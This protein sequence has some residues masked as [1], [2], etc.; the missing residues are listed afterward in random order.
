MPELTG[1]PSIV[2]RVCTAPPRTTKLVFGVAENVREANTPGTVASV[3]VRLL[4]WRNEISIGGSDEIADSEML[5]GV[6]RLVVVLVRPMTRR[7]ERLLSCIVTLTVAGVPAT[8]A[9]SFCVVWK[10]PWFTVTVYTPGGR[11]SVNDPSLPDFVVYDLAPPSTR[12]EASESGAPRESA[13]L[14]LITTVW[15]GAVCAIVSVFVAALTGP[16]RL[17][18]AKAAAVLTRR[19]VRTGSPFEVG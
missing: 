12:T 13:T 7:L 9:K 11:F 10:P 19:S 15:A 3:S 8:T 17:R 6:D 14:P 1:W 16:T 18:Y 5:N 2:T 4:F